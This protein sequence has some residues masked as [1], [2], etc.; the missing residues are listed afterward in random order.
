MILPNLNFF[1]STVNNPTK[2]KHKISIYCNSQFG[3]HWVN[4]IFILKLNIM[5]ISTFLESIESTQ[6]SCDKKNHWIHS[7]GNSRK[8]LKHFFPVL[9][10]LRIKHVSNKNSSTVLLYVYMLVKN[11]VVLFENPRFSVS[12]TVFGLIIDL[13]HPQ[14]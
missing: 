1:W 9:V 10:Q 14:I 4:I 8:N 6:N 5:S 11:E 3:F 2:K 13:V 7:L 12:K